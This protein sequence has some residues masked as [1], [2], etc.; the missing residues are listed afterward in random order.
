MQF[1]KTAFGILALATVVVTFA[2]VSQ[3]K[4]DDETDQWPYVRLQNQNPGLVQRGNTNVNGISNA[5]GFH[6]N[7]PGGAVK[8]SDGTQLA[9]ANDG[10]MGPAGPPGPA[11]PQGPAGPTGPMG[12]QGPQG[13]QGQQGETGATGPQGPAGPQGATGPQGPQGLQGP[14]GP[15]GPAGPGMEF[16]AAS[17]SGQFL[18]TMD[19]FAGDPAVVVVGATTDK[20]LVTA[21]SSNFYTG[22]GSFEASVL[23]FYYVAIRPAAGGAFQSF[24]NGCLTSFWPR[25]DNGYSFDF[26]TTTLSAVVTG[27]AP[28]TYHVGLVGATDGS[29]LD[30]AGTNITVLKSQ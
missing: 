12:P 11:G 17:S 30:P 9:S 29:S 8:F 7:A 4:A 14:Q 6:I 27:L 23:A 21:S 25:L 28:G 5:A 18:D 3:A 19:R 10:P 22:T 26:K 20:L 13:A 24:G 1:S 15:A 16:F 2:F